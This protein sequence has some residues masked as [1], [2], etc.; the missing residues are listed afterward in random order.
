MKIAVYAISKN[1]EQ[2]VKRFCESAK[3]ADYLFILDTGSTDN[4]VSIAKELGIDVEIA[5]ITPWRFDVARNA[6]LDYL[7]HDID[8]CIALDMDEVLIEGWRKHLEQPFFNNITRP[9]YKYTWSWK[10]DGS[11]G[12]EYGG[13]KIHNRYG[14]RW[15]HPVHEVLIS[16]S[17]TQEWCGLEI[18]H[19]PDHAKS[20]G[21]YFDLLKLAVKEDED[22]D[23]GIEKLLNHPKK[24]I[25]IP[26]YGSDP[27]ITLP[28]K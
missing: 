24:E 1:E 10:E 6:A 13:D 2:F 12:L 15:K 14:F 16:E 18:H 17:E 11:P 27:H 8:Y 23:Y 20:R 3:E 7:P 19:F 26:Y 4:T 5:I 25:L 22:I 21:Q 9:R 28:K